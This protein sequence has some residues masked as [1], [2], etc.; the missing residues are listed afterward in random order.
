MDYS[1]LKM[2]VAAKK[3]S[4]V[5]MLYVPGQ[6]DSTAN[7]HNHLIFLISQNCPKSISTDSLDT[8]HP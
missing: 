5:W 7:L 4:D 6:S 8:K 1:V 2:D 3:K